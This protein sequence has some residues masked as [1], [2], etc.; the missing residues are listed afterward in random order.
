MKYLKKVLRIS[1][2]ISVIFALFGI[3]IPFKQNNTNQ[4]CQF[5]VYSSFKFTNL[6]LWFGLQWIFLWNNWLYA[7]K[8]DQACNRFVEELVSTRYGGIWFKILECV[9]R[10]GISMCTDSSGS[11]ELDSDAAQGQRKTVGQKE[12]EE[13]ECCQFWDI[14]KSLIW[15]EL[16]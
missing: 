9:E 7:D 8:L 14:M 2:I 15:A 1:Q 10:G 3:Y 13:V 12:Q 6:A 5:F 4:S 16:H 11:E